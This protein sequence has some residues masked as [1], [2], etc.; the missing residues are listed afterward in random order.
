MRGHNKSV[1]LLKTTM[2][3]LITS[4]GEAKKMKEK[5]FPKFKLMSHKS[6]SRRVA[7]IFQGAM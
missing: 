7:I 3:T 4:N 5:K 2:A 6:P 1:L